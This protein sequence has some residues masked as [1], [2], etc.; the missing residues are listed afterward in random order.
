M[1]RLFPE[2]FEEMT[3]KNWDRK[4]LVSYEPCRG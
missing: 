1:V 3:K 4:E 2:E